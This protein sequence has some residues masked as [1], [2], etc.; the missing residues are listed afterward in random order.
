MTFAIR[1]V[2]AAA[3]LA[4]AAFAL[5][6]PIAAQPV[7]DVP[8]AEVAIAGINTSYV[9]LSNGAPG[10]LYEPVNPGNRAVVAL[11]VMHA[12]GDYLTFSACGELAKRGY[13]VLCA[14]NS[15]SKSGT[16]DDG[17]MDRALIEMK[18]GIAFLRTYPGV[19]K[20]VLFGHSGGATL[21]TAY[22]M[23]A[24]GGVKTC[25]DAAK[26][27]KCP[28]TLAGLPAADGVVLAD[29]NWGQAEMTL[30]SIDPAVTDD[31]SGKARL[32]PGLDM[33]NPANGYAKTGSHY[34]D[35]FRHRFLAAEGRRNNALI[36]KAEARLALIEAGKGDFDDDE[37]FIIAGASFIGNRLFS[38]D[39]SLLEHSTQPWPLI[40]P[41]G[42][43][44][45]EVIH[46][47]RKA[48]G[49]GNPS[50]RWNGAL[51]TTV[52][53]FLSSYA[54]RTRPD[55]GY[56]ASTI[57]GVDWRS[58]YASPPGNVEGISAPLF[59]LGMSGHWEGLAAETIYL[60]AKSAD[61]SIAFVEG[62]DHIY[63]PCHNCIAPPASYGDT[64][65]TTYDAIDQWLA[66]PG[67][68]VD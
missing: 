59:A 31:S 40:H 30:L 38:E 2:R 21:M 55:F 15:T 13:R 36:A 39:P 49:R 23:I 28:D 19:R 44:T 14:N 16:F 45:T 50:A 64:I 43:V 4:L 18:D 25:Q 56:D 48:E 35:T 10:V 20:I 46:S 17:V 62:A 47:L 24:E 33:Y 22:Q 52:R 67:R 58:T 1:S 42:H 9:R 27:H 61:K 3:S 12:S 54:I 8:G 37:P 51:R 57:T 63:L 53:N 11:F 65:K 32:D 26:I 60:H 68:F 6:S 66:K 34:S 7:S 29:A 5:P 41:D